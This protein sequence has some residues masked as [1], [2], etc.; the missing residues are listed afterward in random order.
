MAI[1]GGTHHIADFGEVFAYVF[2]EIIRQRR[3]ARGDRIIRRALKHRQMLRCRRNH[4]NRLNTRGP[5]ADHAN[6]LAR[7]IHTLMRP[8]AGVVPFA[9]KIRDT[10]NL[11][12]IGR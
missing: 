11:R 1:D 6:A 2:L 5:G 10:I 7:E 4:R 12:Q 8:F 3:I 9:L